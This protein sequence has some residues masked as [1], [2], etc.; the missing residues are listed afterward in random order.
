LTH[1]TYVPH[2]S[3]KTEESVYT[4]QFNYFLRFG[5]YSAEIFRACRLV[6]DTGIHA[7]GWT[8]ER[9]VNYILEHS[10]S[11]KGNTEQ[12]VDRYITWPA[13]ALGYKMGQIR[14]RQMR[15]EAEKKLGKK[16]CLKDFHEVVLRSA[17]PLEVLQEEIE[18]YINSK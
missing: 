2:A 18:K 5:H 13:Q 10:A 6:V 12:E 17:G 1:V 4:A 14:I 15:E 3:N 16:F 9:A 7:L 8:R 11:S